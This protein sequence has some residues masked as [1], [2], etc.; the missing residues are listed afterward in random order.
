MPDEE[1]LKLGKGVA[2][3][4]SQMKRLPQEDDTWEA[5]FRALPRPSEQGET[6]YQGMVVSTED[7]SLLSE[8]P[9]HG[10]P[11][12][13]DLATLLAHAMRRPLVGHAHRPRLVRLRGHHQWRGLFPHLEEI[14]IGVEVS[15][16]RGLPVIED[17]YAE[18]LQQL[19]E[20]QRVGMVVPTPEQAMVEGMFPAIA[21]YVRGYGNVEI[22][23]QELFGFVARALHEGGTQ[24]EDERPGTLAE[25]LAALEDG[26]VRWFEE[27]RVEIDRP[28][29]GTR[30]RRR[31]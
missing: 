3:V 6:H 21:E 9:V 7:G 11:S 18:L 29:S 15:V 2:F 8:L 10:R 4:K 5:D 20:E 26:L 24:V 13:N 19:R 30:K 16:E 25:A 23:E 28:A 22:G 12:V 27:Q 31:P 17:A 14:G 1:K